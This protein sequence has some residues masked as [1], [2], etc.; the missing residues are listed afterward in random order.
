M[1]HAIKIADIKYPKDVGYRVVWVFDNSS[2]HNA[3][4][5]DALNANN[6]NAKPG[7][8]QPCLRDTEWDERPQ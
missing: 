3:Y 4:A 6:M 1:E 8:K 2:C 7:G 5:D